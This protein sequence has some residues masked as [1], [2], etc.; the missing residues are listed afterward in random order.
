MSIEEDMMTLP[1]IYWTPKLHK[2]PVKFR[3]I[4]ASKRCTTKTVSKNLSSIFTLFQKQIDTYNKKSHYFSGI[5]QYWIVN[6]REPVLNAVKRSWARRTAKCVTSFDFSTL[7]TKIPHDKL[8]DVLNKIIN[9]AFQGGTRSK[10]SIHKSGTASWVTDKSNSTCIYTKQSIMDAVDFLINNCHFK[11]GDKLFRQAIGIPMGSDPAP[12]FANLFLYHYES[13]WLDSTKKKNNI[14]ARKF[15]QV[16][17]YIDDLIAINDGHSFETYHKEIY[18]EELQLNRENETYLSTDFLDLH[19]ELQNGIFTTRLFDKRDHFGFDITRLPY[20]DSNIPERMFYS[21]IAAECLRI[22]RATSLS[23][24]A[25]TSIKAVIARM[26]KQGAMV[27][28][29][30]NSLRKMFIR[31]QIYKK[32]SVIENSFLDSLFA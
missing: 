4:I 8:I 26:I 9:F 31:H 11:F 28:K 24:D 7:Y 2:N 1:D 13:S 25:I 12:A 16:Y 10:I 30:K 27:S 23:D 21:S 14:L 32:F 20:R 17:R 3:F 5:K 22:C 18:P 19:I 29:I 6:N 15:G